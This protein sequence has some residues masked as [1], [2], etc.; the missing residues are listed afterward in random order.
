MPT[1]NLDLI[2]EKWK[3]SL[4]NKP[5]N[6]EF[7]S[8]NFDELFDEFNSNGVSFEEAHEYLQVAIKIHLPPPG[9][10]KQW[11]KTSKHD[12]R[13][14]DMSEKEFIDGWHKDISDKAT[15]SFYNIYP[16]PKEH[17]EEPK[18]YGDNKISEKEYKLLRDHASKFKPVDLKSL[19][20]ES[21]ELLTEEEL[22]DLVRNH[23]DE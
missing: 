6:A 3:A 22:L 1:S 19:D 17:D 13:F 11:W 16:I 9:L 14:S 20:T 23:K 18:I 15:N 8:A 2:F 10:A 4:K 7:V 5:R 12:P 21:S